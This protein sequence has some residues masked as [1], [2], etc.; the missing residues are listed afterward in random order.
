MQ[1]KIQLRYIGSGEDVAYNKERSVIEHESRL[2]SG[3]GDIVNVTIR[4]LS[5]SFNFYVP[6]V[7]TV[8]VKNKDAVKS[9]LA[10]FEVL[11]KV[12]K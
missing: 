10:L 8:R 12:A 1:K 11:W 5:V 4:P 6:E 9:Q 3:I 2:I 7:M